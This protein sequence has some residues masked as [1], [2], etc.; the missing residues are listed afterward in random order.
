MSKKRMNAMLVGTFSPA[1][2]VN[3]D[4]KLRDAEL[5]LDTRTIQF[6]RGNPKLIQVDCII[7]NSQKGETGSFHLYTRDIKLSQRDQNLLKNCI[8]RLRI[9]L[10]RRISTPKDTST[11]QTKPCSSGRS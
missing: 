5:A 6:V 2:G 11:M 8:R 1:D 10:K 3:F 9:R 7:T 4:V